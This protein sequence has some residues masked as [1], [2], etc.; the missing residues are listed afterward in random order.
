MTIVSCSYLDGSEARR[1]GME[2]MYNYKNELQG[3]NYIN[4]IKLIDF[5]IIEKELMYM[6]KLM[7][8][9]M[10]LT[11]ISGCTAFEIANQMEKERGVEC[12]YNKRGGV[13]NCRYME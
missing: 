4:Q 6:R 2:C 7:I 13:E 8:L 11:L 9:L 12:R 5:K 10:L 3:C 1:R